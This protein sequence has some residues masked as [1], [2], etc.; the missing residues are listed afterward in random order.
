[1]I[2][3]IFNF[4]KGFSLT[5]PKLHR[6]CTC[7]SH[8]QPSKYDSTSV[9][10]ISIVMWS[11]KTHHMVQNI[12]FEFLE[13]YESLNYSFSELFTSP[14]C[15]MVSKVTD[16]QR[17]SKTK[18]NVR[19]ILLILQFY[20]VR[21][22]LCFLRSHHNMFEKSWWMRLGIRTSTFNYTFTQL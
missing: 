12:K 16:V 9:T 2:T 17:L 19:I 7:T 22:V 15:Q 8:I 10:K 14:F 13:S 21:Y 20:S 4:K 11:E 18:K 1:M 5:S 6:L 3:I